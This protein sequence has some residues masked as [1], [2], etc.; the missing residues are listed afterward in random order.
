MKYG[1]NLLDKR[2]EVLYG[3][4][5]WLQRFVQHSCSKNTD[6]SRS[7]LK[8][9]SELLH[10]GKLAGSF[11]HLLHQEEKKTLTLI[12]IFRCHTGESDTRQ[13][14]RFGSSVLSSLHGF[15]SSVSTSCLVVESLCINR[16]M[17]HFTG[18]DGGELTPRSHHSI[19]PKNTQLHALLWKPMSQWT[20][21][22]REA[23]KQPAN[24]QLLQQAGSKWQRLP[25]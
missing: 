21:Q 1:I 5:L 7:V 20:S 19:F 16:T 6:P 23:E 18:R 11:K 14:S 22:H 12:I 25:L 13:R 4:Y 17:S 9:S 2:T 8:E 10:A 3:A 15:L 24:P